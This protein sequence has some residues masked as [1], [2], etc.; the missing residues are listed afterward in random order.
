MTRILVLPGFSAHN[1]VWL[2]KISVG[3]ES[4]GEVI[5]IPW[6]HWQADQTPADWQETELKRIE[7]RIGNKPIV[8]VA[9]SI[10]TF[11]AARLLGNFGDQVEKLVLC[12]L[13]LND[14]D[15]EQHPVYRHLEKLSPNKVLVLQNNHDPHG[16]D[17]QVRKLFQKLNLKHQV[18]TCE[19]DTHEYIY[20]HHI[21]SF[22]E[23]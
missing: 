4:L 5:A 16:S 17:G 18:T 19:G 1:Q 8:I 2:E 6:Q 15:S 12:G 11:L 14:I 21:V 20:P 13:P 22:L 9:K 23:K 7:A 10:G 3:L